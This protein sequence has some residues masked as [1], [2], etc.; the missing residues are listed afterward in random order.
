MSD[1]RVWLILLQKKIL[2]PFTPAE[3]CSLKGVTLNSLVKKKHWKRWVR[4]SKIGELKDLL[5]GQP[6]KFK[7]DT[8]NLSLRDEEV[9]VAN[10][11]PDPYSAF[12]VWLLIFLTLFY[13]ALFLHEKF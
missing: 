5:V 1:E 11:S 13:L 4:L 6:Q 2:G 12:I 10:H 9:V 8:K 3:L 7:F